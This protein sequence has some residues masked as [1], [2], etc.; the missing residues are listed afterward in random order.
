MRPS[1]LKNAAD[2][3]CQP[4]NLFRALRQC[5]KKVEDLKI[6]QA[7][8]ESLM[9]D[10]IRGILEKQSLINGNL[11]EWKMIFLRSLIRLARPETVVETGV[12][13]GSSS[14]VILDALQQNQ[15]G[16]LYSVDLPLV[17]GENGKAT[18]LTTV[19]NPNQVGWLVPDS[20]R[21]RWS[22]TLGDSLVRLPKIVQ[23]LSSLDI[24]FHDSFHSYGHMMEEFRIVWPHLK[25]RGFL[26]SD[27]IFIERHAAIYDFAKE[28]DR[29]FKTFLQ[30]GVICNE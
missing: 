30:L 27:D 21:P 20:L 10:V 22:L 1:Y 6:R 2:H 19:Q 11:S 17:A 7:I 25:K 9:C 15:K 3:F 23:N 13:H 28:K 16:R 26:L 14:A 18:L 29:P 4:S 5:F 24:F 12:A 8:Q